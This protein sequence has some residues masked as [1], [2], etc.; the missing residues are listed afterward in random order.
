MTRFANEGRRTSTIIRDNSVHEAYKEI[1]E[2]LGALIGVV[3][4]TY[5]YRRIHERTGLCAK[6]IAF[7][8]N[9]TDLTQDTELC[10]LTRK[11]G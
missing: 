9:H 6:T 1:A 8:L 5:I 2:E 10:E 7:I 11:I 4:R 3:S